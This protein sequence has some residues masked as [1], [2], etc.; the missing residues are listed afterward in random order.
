MELVESYVYLRRPFPQSDSHMIVDRIEV[1]AEKSESSHKSQS[2]DEDED[3][4]DGESGD[5]III[6]KPESVAEF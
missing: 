2:E 1:I 3:E 4:N 5:V 6:T